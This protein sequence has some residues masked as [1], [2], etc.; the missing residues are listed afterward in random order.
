[1][2]RSRILPPMSLPWMLNIDKERFA[3][4][5]LGNAGELRILRPYRR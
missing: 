5:Y 1:M 2:P 3:V 4:G